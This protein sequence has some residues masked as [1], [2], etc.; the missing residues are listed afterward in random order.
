VHDRI[1]SLRRK[2]GAIITRLTLQRF[3]EVLLPSQESDWSCISVL[4]TSVLFLSTISLNRCLPRKKTKQNF[5]FQIN[6]VILIKLDVCMIF[7]YL[8]QPIYI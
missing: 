8:Q 3:I 4:G 2:V 6:E 1:V 5:V 7:F